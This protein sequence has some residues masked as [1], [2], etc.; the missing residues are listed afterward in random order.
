MVKRDNSPRVIEILV[1]QN[2]KTT[3]LEPMAR[4]LFDDGKLVGEIS[5]WA[6]KTDPP[7]YKTFLGKTA[8]LTPANDE[9]SFVSPKP[10][11]RKAKLVVVEDKKIRYELQIT[12]VVGG[13]EII[14]KILKRTES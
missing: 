8:L 13:T 10:V 3:K 14:A 11:H 5:D 7:V 12:K 1:S 9:C 6:Q 2:D 4:M